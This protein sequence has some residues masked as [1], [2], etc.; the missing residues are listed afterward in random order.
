VP[1]GHP[2]SAALTVLGELLRNG[3]LHRAIREKGGAYG[4]GASQDSGDAIFRFYSYR[5]PRSLETLED[6]DRSIHWLL[7][8]GADELQLEEA[9]LGVVS[10]IDKPGSPAGEAKATFLN[11]LFGRTPEQRSAFRQAILE[12]SLADIVRVADTYLT[13]SD[14]ANVA[15]LTHAKA[16]DALPSNFAR[17]KV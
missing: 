4:S 9:I 16:A 1:V 14:K 5:D 13:D 12:V 2:D 10:S 17:F 7:D 6:F 11:T 3:Y 8:G 15:V